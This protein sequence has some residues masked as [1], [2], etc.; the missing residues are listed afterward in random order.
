M[1]TLNDGSAPCTSDE[2]LA[3]LQDAG[4]DARTLDHAPVFTVEEARATRGELPGAHT[5]NLFL[6]NRKGRMWLVTVEAD[7]RVDLRELAAA[8]DAGRFSFGSEERLMRWL[9][10]TKGAVTPF[11]VVNDRE[12]KVTFAIDGALL[13]AEWINAHPLTNAR[14]TALRPADL[15]RFC[16]EHGHEAIRLVLD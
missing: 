14:T 12:G 7:Q 4:I 9:G 5:K 8:L 6:R 13:Q 3:L 11:G 16:A 2:L 15:L 10:L 1:N